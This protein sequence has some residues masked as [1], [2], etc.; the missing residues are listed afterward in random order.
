[1]SMWGKKAQSRDF[2]TASMHAVHLRPAR[3]SDRDFAISLRLDGAE[4]RLAA[5]GPVD[6]RGLRARFEKNYRR[7]RSTIICLDGEDI[8]WMQVLEAKDRIEIEQL[9][10]VGPYRNRGLGRKLIEDI[11]ARAQATNRAVELSVIRGNPAIRLYRR[12]GF[13][14]VGEEPEKLHMRWEATAR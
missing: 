14:L 10:L 3:A 7:G 9:H 12:L 2:P 13:R 11:F 1:M 5:L 4:S 8:G 6:E